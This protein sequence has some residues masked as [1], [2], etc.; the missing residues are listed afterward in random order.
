MRTGLVKKETTQQQGSRSKH[1]LQ[2][3]PG[4]SSD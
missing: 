1:H 3:A 2:T 4:K